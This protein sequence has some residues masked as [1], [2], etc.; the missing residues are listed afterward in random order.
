M[1]QGSARAHACVALGRGVAVCGQV[2]GFRSNE[3]ERGLLG[4]GHWGHALVHGARLPKLHASHDPHT[5]IWNLHVF[6]F[7]R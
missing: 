7:L 2:C 3:D 6:A 5:L 4:T 1:H